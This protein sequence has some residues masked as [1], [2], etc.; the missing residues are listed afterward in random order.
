MQY[1]KKMKTMKISLLILFFAGTLY[2]QD[3]SFNKHSNNGASFYYGIGKTG[4]RD[5]YISDEKYTGWT[6]CFGV[7]WSGEHTK[8][9]FKMGIEY[10]YIDQLKNNNVSSEI[11]NALFHQTYLYKILN[12]EKSLITLGPSLS[13]F[14]FENSPDIAGNHINSVGGFL[15]LGIDGL[16]YS[17]INNKLSFEVFSKLGVISFGGKTNDDNSGAKLQSPLSN[18]YFNTKILLNYQ[19]FRYIGF[20]AGYENYITRIT[21]WDY[22]IGVSNNVCVLL[23]IVI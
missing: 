22:Y 7:Y 10:V 3:T 2:C 20:S 6:N 14:Y 1:I 21:S 13:I 5:E 11:T 23:K 19:P 16:F 4:I 9:L 8:Y 17:R 18:T 12:S 15:N